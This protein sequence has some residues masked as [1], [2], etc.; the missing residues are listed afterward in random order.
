MLLGERTSIDLSPHLRAIQSGRAY[1]SAHTHPSDCSFSS[2]D[3]LLLY[4]YPEIRV[5][6]VFGV[7]GTTYP[8]S[9]LGTLPSP[10]ILLAAYRAAYREHTAAYAQATAGA[11]MGKRAAEYVRSHAVWGTIAEICGLRYT[12]LEPGMTP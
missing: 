5:V 7:R 8:F 4:L 2:D 1:V 10:D 9:R 3:A 12:R 11:T 6:A